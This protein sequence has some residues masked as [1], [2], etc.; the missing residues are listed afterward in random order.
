MDEF[1]ARIELCLPYYLHFHPF[2]PL[3]AC[4]DATKL[5]LPSR[6]CFLPFLRIIIN[7]PSFLMVLCQS[8]P[9]V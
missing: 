2:R 1:N 6:T 5:L 4:A 3:S 9:R 7:Y 8:I